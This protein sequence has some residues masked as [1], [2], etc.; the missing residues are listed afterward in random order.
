MS[1]PAAGLALTPALPL[2]LGQGLLVALRHSEGVTLGEAAALC[3]ALLQ[4]DALLER[5]DEADML[6]E[7]V[8]LTLAVP[9]REGV[10]EGLLVP[11]LQWVRRAEGERRGEEEALAQALTLRHC[12]GERVCEG[13]TVGLVSP[14]ALRDTPGEAEPVALAHSVS[15]TDGVRE[16][17]S[18]AERRELA[19]RL[20][21]DEAE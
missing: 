14:E 7:R 15:V 5:A 19:L 16:G 9:L 2:L 18:E 3:E 4:A 6:P 21:V 1:V 10:G 11:L 13:D 17:I 20:T 12:V 8:T